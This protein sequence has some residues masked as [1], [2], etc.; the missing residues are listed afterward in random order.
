MAI[1]QKKTK[2]I[3]EFKPEKLDLEQDWVSR[4]PLDTAPYPLV[5]R[6]RIDG[7]VL[8][9]YV[10]RHRDRVEESLLAHGAVLFRGFNV[11]SR[12]EFRDVIGQVNDRFMSYSDRSSPRTEISSQVYTSTDHPADQFINMHN[13]LAYSQNWP[14]KIAFYCHVEPGKDGRTPIADVR[15]VFRTL[16]SHTVSVFAEKGVMYRRHLREGIGLSWKQVYQ[17]EDKSKV[18]SYCRVNA[19]DFQWTDHDGLIVRW[20][21]PAIQQH[22][23]TGENVWFNHGYFFNSRAL[24]EE[25]L[26]AFA[27]EDDLSF[28]TYFG[29]GSRIPGELLDEIKRAYDDATVAFPWQRGDIL[30]LDNMLMAHGRH[31]FEAPREINVV[32]CSP[33]Y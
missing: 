4:G 32:M 24:S 5:F 25:V 28:N 12:E 26:R 6:P 10:R 1:P 30:L 22:P 3:L 33:R 18:E 11:R 23:Q 21:R 27:S 17:T 7:V 9:D 14:M 31:P 13:E 16:S 20:V 8:R 19:V 15:R 29:N 2:S